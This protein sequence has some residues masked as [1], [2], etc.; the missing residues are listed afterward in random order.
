MTNQI[1]G[2][3]QNMEFS[4]FLPAAAPLP[5]PEQLLERPR[6]RGVIAMIL[7]PVLVWQRPR[8]ARL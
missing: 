8:S 5:M 4:R 2:S 3:D 1:N 7:S 6:R